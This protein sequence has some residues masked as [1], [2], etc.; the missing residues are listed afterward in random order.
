M[1]KTLALILALTLL[2][3]LMACSKKDQP[4]A[5][6]TT[7]QA[8]DAGPGIS[9][10]NKYAQQ[11]I[12]IFYAEIR[13]GT[14]AEAILR[15]IEEAVGMSCEVAEMPEGYLNAFS[16][17]VTGFQKCTG[18]FPMIGAQPFV[19]YIF[20]AENAAEYGESLKKIADPRWNICTEAEEMVVMNYENYLLF[21]MVPEYS[22]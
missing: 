15:Q 22:E 20:E 19:C 10:E 5:G 8:A 9:S 3:S 7:D 13:K 17:E 2:C 21:A 1:K 11:I 6:T 4:A 12:D 16:D 18:L 14:E